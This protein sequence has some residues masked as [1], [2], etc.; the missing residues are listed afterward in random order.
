MSIDYGPFEF[1]TAP[2]TGAEWFTSAMSACGMLRASVNDAVVGFDGESNGKLRVSMVRH[3][4]S[5]LR[6]LWEGKIVCPFSG[7]GLLD[8]D[9]RGFSFREFV[10][11]NAMHCEGRLSELVLSYRANSFLRLE[12]LPDAFH[13]LMEAVGVDSRKMPLPPVP[14]ALVSR[15]MLPADTYTRLIE[16]ER[17][18]IDLFDYW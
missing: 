9:H 4:L 7:S 1:A 15:G 12:D 2:G 3:P 11:K 13:D 8:C 10:G 6:A 14:D 16:A 18:L 5:W 17:D